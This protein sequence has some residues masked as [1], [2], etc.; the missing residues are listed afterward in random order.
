MTSSV[1]NVPLRQMAAEPDARPVNVP[2][3]FSV[4]NSLCID[5]VLCR[6]TAPRHFRRD[7]D[8]DVSYVYR[9]PETAAELANC[10]TAAANCPVGAIGDCGESV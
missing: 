7:G 4:D 6:H 8:H 2:G 3:R 10:L 5:C 1:G 9:Q